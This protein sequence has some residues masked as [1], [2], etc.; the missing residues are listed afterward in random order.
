MNKSELI[1]HV[2]QEH[3]CTKVDAERA[4]NMFTS[5]IS[6][7]LSK[8]EEIALVGFGAFYVTK[9]AARDGRNPKTGAKLKIAAR[10]Q[11]K[12]RAGKTLK[13]ACN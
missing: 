4:I 3:S 7:L 5:S 12:F 10:A 8:G 13:D 6:T 2:A 1:D 11:P 9:A